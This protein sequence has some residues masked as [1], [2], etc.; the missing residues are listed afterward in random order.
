MNGRDRAIRDEIHRDIW[1][2]PRMQPSLIP[3]NSSAFEP[4]NNC[5]PASMFSPPPRTTGSPIPLVPTTWQAGSPLTSKKCT[6]GC[7]QKT[8]KNSFNS[9]PCCTILGIRPI[10]TCWRRHGCT[11]PSA[12]TR[13][14]GGTSLNHPIPPSVKPCVPHWVSKGSTSLRPHGRPRRPRGR[15]HPSVHERNRQ[16]PVGR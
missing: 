6:L 5:P 3:P 9:L 7:C 1:S 15:A 2:L 14:G 8:T 10:H 16:Q 11:P 13:L 4:F 12:R